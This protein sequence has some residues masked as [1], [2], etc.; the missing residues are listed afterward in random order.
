MT[1]TIN[2]VYLDLLRQLKEG[3]D[4]QPSLSAREITAF[5]CQADKRQTAEWAHVYLEDATVRQAQALCDRCLDGEPLAYILGEWDFYGLTFNLNQSVLIPRPD[6]ER[7]CELAIAEAYQIIKPRIIDLCC[8]SGCIGLA[9]AHEITEAQVV[10]VDISE[11]A[12]TLSLENAQRL[13]VQ[14]RY[15]AVQADVMKKPELSEKAFDI[16]VANPPYISRPEMAKLDKSV[17]DFEPLIALYGGDDGLA[18]YPPIC[19]LWG[20]LLA[21]GGM[22][23]L[24][25]GYEQAQKVAEILIN[26]QYENIDISE[27]LLGIPRV[28]YGYKPEKK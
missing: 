6:T 28:V 9:I 4:P 12:V 24:E 7:L 19:E 2:E 8:G 1:K 23:F 13:G 26:H 22:I 21:P 16:L 14:E 17:V 20:E 15:T 3:G 10:G 5:A 25:C 27:D 11:E 18:F